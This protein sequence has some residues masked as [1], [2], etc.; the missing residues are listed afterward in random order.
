MSKHKL[1][2]DDFGELHIYAQGKL[3]GDKVKYK[4]S[5]ICTIWYPVKDNDNIKDEEAGVCFTFPAKDTNDL[6][7]LLKEIKE[8]KADIYIYNEE[9]EKKREEWER[10]Q[11][12][13]VEKIK[14]AFEDL[15]VH[16]TP[17]I[18]VCLASL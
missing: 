16:I 12:T 6:I 15:G 5:E 17:F 7:A 13:L 11:E 1:N 14:D 4:D 3:R 2:E 10:K 9:E 8:N 18:G